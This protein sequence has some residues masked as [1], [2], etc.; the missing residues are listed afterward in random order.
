MTKE[1]EGRGQPGPWRQLVLSRDRI[2]CDGHSFNEPLVMGTHRNVALL[3]HN[4][5]MHRE[6]PQASLSS[7]SLSITPSAFSSQGSLASPLNLCF[8]SNPKK[9]FQSLL[10]GR[11]IF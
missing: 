8:S 3:Q 6:T 5:V 11:K 9:L 10:Q 4:G 2:Q 7:C 1:E